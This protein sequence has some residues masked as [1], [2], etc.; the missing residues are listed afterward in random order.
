MGVVQK[1]RKTGSQKFQLQ[2]EKIVGRR[3]WRKY[4]RQ[5]ERERERECVCVCVRERERERE[6]DGERERERE[7]KT[8]DVRTRA[9]FQ[10]KYTHL[11]V[12]LHVVVEACCADRVEFVAR[13][14][15]D[16]A[17]VALL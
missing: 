14:A 2:E 7:K 13:K 4:A 5:R 12:V 6:W 9:R 16:E 3:C 1:G 15:A 8:K 10:T 11:V 17:A